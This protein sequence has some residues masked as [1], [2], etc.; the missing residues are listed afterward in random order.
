M[1]IENT[2]RRRSANLNLKLPQNCEPANDS[3]SWLSRWALARF[4]ANKPR[5]EHSAAGRESRAQ[6]IR[7]WIADGTFS[8]RLDQTVPWSSTMEARKRVMGEM[9]KRESENRNKFK[10]LIQT[11]RSKQGPDL[12]DRL[13]CPCQGKRSQ[14]S[15]WGFTF[16]TS[17]H[18]KRSVLKLLYRFVADKKDSWIRKPLL[19]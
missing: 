5:T 3:S 16:R 15:G 4:T 2:T 9:V 17:E 6:E 13:S 7:I 18:P 11:L 19:F 10:M 8:I 12:T 14:R 1:Q